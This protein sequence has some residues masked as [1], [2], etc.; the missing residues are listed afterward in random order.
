MHFIQFYI[1]GNN[2]YGSLVKCKI[3]FKV[4]RINSEKAT[5]KSVQQ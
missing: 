4:P 5:R 2:N 1:Q 3:N